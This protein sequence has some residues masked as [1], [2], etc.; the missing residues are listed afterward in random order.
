MSWGRRKRATS[1]LGAEH[2]AHIGLDSR[3][4][5]SWPEPKADTYPTEPHSA[6]CWNFDYR[7]EDTDLD[8][9]TST[10]YRLVRYLLRT[11][12]C[13]LTSD[14]SHSSGELSG[15]GFAPLCADSALLQVCTRNVASGPKASLMQQCV[16]L[17]YR[18]SKSLHRHGDVAVN[19]P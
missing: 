7:K 19:T 4:P 15:A 12:L 13:S 11:V 14:S 10:F 1:R 8:E 17:W 16:M 5:G 6:G 9:A 18:L 2:G 3:T